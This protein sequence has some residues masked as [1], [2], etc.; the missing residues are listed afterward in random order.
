MKNCMLLHTYAKQSNFKKYQNI[1]IYPLIFNKYYNR[2]LNKT[3]YNQ[4]QVFVRTILIMFNI[5]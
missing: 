4:F 5:S 2:I 3:L 1:T